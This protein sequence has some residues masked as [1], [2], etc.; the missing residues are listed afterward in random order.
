MVAPRV[1]DVVVVGGG[2]M[3]SSVAYH[4]A[5]ADPAL[6]IVVVERDPSYIRASS[7]L[8]VGNVRVQ[9]NLEENIRI[10][11]YALAVFER[12]DEE[13]SVE[14]Q[15]PDIRFR[16]EGNLFLHAPEGSAGAESGMALQ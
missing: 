7:S 1:C 13:M 4:L 11:L 14:G 10:S 9:F 15:R 6:E 2:V 16:L 8:S 12:F 3:G 5:A